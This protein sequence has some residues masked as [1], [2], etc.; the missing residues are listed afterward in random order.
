M[1]ALIQNRNRHLRFVS[2]VAV[3]LY[4]KIGTLVFASIYR[5]NESTIK[6]RRKT[7][8]ENRYLNR[9]VVHTFRLEII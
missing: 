2:K 4:S 5:Y 1:F 9:W 8:W 3:L 6:H 7:L